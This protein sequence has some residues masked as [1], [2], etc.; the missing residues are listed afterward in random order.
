MSLYLYLNSCVLNSITT[1]HSNSNHMFF[2]YSFI[3]E[4][5]RSKGALQGISASVCTMYVWRH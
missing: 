5:M 3:F 4:F 2:L 1:N